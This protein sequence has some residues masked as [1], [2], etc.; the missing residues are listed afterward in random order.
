MADKGECE[1]F[2]GH[3]DPYLLNCDSAHL[4]FYDI[5]ASSMAFSLIDRH[6]GSGQEVGWRWGGSANPQELRT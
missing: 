4:R 1:E 5:P 2:T 6:G 3:G